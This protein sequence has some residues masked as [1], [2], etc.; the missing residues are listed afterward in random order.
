MGAP[1]RSAK[2]ISIAGTL[3]GLMRSWWIIVFVE[4]IAAE[5]SS[6]INT[7]DLFTYTATR[8]ASRALIALALKR[9]LKSSLKPIDALVMSP[10]GQS[11]TWGVVRRMS[12]LPSIADIRRTSQKVRDVPEADIGST[13]RS[14][15]KECEHKLSHIEMV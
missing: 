1:S 2:T 5:A 7:T 12:G 9:A 10:V 11:Q 3:R 6:R 4:L 14:I 13:I 8:S 15:A